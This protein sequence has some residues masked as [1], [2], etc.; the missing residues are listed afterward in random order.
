MSNL[1]DAQKTALEW[2]KR[3]PGKDVCHLVL[4]ACFDNARTASA[5]KKTFKAKKVT[6]VLRDEVIKNPVQEN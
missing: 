4:G 3:H 6:V 2:F 1:N 5:Y